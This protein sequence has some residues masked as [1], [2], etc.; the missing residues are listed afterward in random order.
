MKSPTILLNSSNSTVQSSNIPNFKWINHYPSKRLSNLSTY[1][2]HIE[3]PITYFS[4]HPATFPSVYT[5]A[6]IHLSVHL[7]LCQLNLSIQPLIHPSNHPS[8]NSQL[9][10]PASGP[11]KLPLLSTL[12]WANQHCVTGKCDCH[13]K[14]FSANLPPQTHSEM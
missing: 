14:N 3:Q 8:V 11:S 13:V 5:D 9:V 7:A 12:R 6:S 2:S 10:H 4:I 1:Y